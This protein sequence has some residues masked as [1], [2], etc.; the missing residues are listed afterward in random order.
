M[1]GGLDTVELTDVCAAGGEPAFL[2]AASGTRSE[3]MSGLRKRNDKLK[4]MSP[5][6]ATRYALKIHKVY[7]NLPAGQ[8]IPGGREWHRIWCEKYTQI[9]TDLTRTTR[10]PAAYQGDETMDKIKHYRVGHSNNVRGVCPHKHKTVEMAQRCLD[11]DQ[12]DCASL[13]GGSYSDRTGVY[14]VHTSGDVS[15]PYDV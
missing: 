14:A 15:G 1:P 7:A 12:R 10:R 4:A 5:E 11:Q 8:P 9:L 6:E 2:T 3:T 13:G